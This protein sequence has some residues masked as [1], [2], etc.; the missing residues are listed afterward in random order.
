MPGL[1]SCPARTCSLA[2]SLS[3]VGTWWRAMSEWLCRVLRLSPCPAHNLQPW[4]YAKICQTP[5]RQQCQTETESEVLP[6]PFPFL[7]AC[8]CVSRVP[9]RIITGT[10]QRCTILGLVCGTFELTLRSLVENWSQNAHKSCI[11]HRSGLRG[12]EGK[13]GSVLLWVKTIQKRFSYLQFKL[14]FK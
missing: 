2:Y 3:S 9:T 8:S 5:V 14:I 11:K 4:S 10:W 13:A 1:V 6:S 7:P 12:K